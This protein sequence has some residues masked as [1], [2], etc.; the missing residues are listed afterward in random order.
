VLTDESYV[1]MEGKINDNKISFRS[2]SD[3]EC[4]GEAIYLLGSYFNHS[5]EPNIEVQFAMKGSTASYVAI[6]YV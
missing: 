4:N 1:A 6:R 2:T 5:C 3:T